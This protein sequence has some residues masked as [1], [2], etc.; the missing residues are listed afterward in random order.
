VERKRVCQHYDENGRRID[1][2]NDR[3]KMESIIL[4]SA[5]ILMKSSSRRG[6]REC[7]EVRCNNATFL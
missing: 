7:G 2:T 6:E 5:S 1:V 3:T 4:V